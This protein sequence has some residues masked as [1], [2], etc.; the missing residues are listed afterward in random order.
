M[1]G[2]WSG[3]RLVV[4][5][6]MVLGALAVPTVSGFAGIGALIDVAAGQT[7][8]TVTESTRH[9]TTTSR[10]DLADAPPPECGFPGSDPVLVDE[11]SVPGETTISAGVT[12]GPAVIFVG[13]DQSVEHQVLAGQV[14][15]DILT[16][17]ETI[18]TQYFQATAAGEACAVLAAAARFTG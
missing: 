14:N 7:A 8:N 16:T 9:V 17:Y 4:A 6:A 18:V 13:P 2:R 1:I 3:R 11:T 12:V 5:A 15:T 10:V